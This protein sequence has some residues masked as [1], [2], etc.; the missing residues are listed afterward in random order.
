MIGGMTDP[1][2]RPKPS[3]LNLLGFAGLGVMAATLSVLDL[4]TGHLA[5]GLLT[6][7]L[8]LA[9]AGLLFGG[10]AMRRRARLKPAAV[11]PQPPKTLAEST[12][13]SVEAQRQRQWDLITER[14]YRAAGGREP[15]QA[16]KVKPADWLAAV[17]DEFMRTGERPRGLVLP[18]G[19]IGVKGDV[20]PTR[21]KQQREIRVTMWL[22][23]G[24]VPWEGRCGEGAANGLPP[25]TAVALPEPKAPARFPV[26]PPARRDAGRAA[27]AGSVS[28]ADMA[29]GFAR[30]GAVLGSCAHP[31]AEPVDLITGERVAWLCPECD[32]QLP[33]GW[34]RG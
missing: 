27:L 29:A 3:R 25:G 14:A 1:R 19:V 20:L 32:A 15:R 13:E 30:L 22:E 18:E 17:A 9:G 11:P 4:A 16:P 34:R 23:N 12:A 10:S 33:A 31:D 8:F 6:G 7:A 28:M 26:A 2:A 24:N 5:V 21:R